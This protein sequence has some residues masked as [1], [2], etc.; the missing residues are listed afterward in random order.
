LYTATE[1]TTTNQR[2]NATIHTRDANHR[3]TQTDY[4]DGNGTLLARETFTYCDQADSQCSNNPLGHLKTHRLKNGAYVH[5]RYNPRGLLI[6]KW[7]PTWN[8]SASDAD[9]KTHYDY[10]TSGPWTDRVLTVTGPPPNW[11][12]SSQA[13]ET[14]EYDRAL[15]A[16]GITDLLNGAAQAGRGLVTKITHADGK[17]QRFAY[18]AYGNKRWEDN[19]LR[20]ATSY[21]YDEYNRLLNVTRPLNEITNY[22]YNPTNGGGSRLSHTTNNPDTVTVRT[23]ATTS[24]TTR[25]DYDENFRKTSATAADGTASAATTWFH[26]DNVGN[27]DYVTDPRGSSTPSAQWTTYTDYDSRNRK[28][29][30][31]EPLSRTTQFYYDDGFNLTR[32]V[33]AVGTPEVATETKVYDGLNRIKSD[34]VP[35]DT[36][37]NIVTQFQYNPWSGDPQTVDIRQPAPVIDG[38]SHNCQ[39]KYDAAGLKTQ[40]TYHDGSSQSWACD[41]AHNL[42]SRTTVAGEIQNFGYDNRNRKTLEWWDG[43]PADGEWRAF[44]YDDASHLTLATNGTGAYWANFIADVRRSYNAAGRLTMDRQTVYVNGVP[45]TKDVDYPTYT[46]DGRVTRM[47]VNGASPAYDYTFSYDRMGRFE[48]IQLTGSSVLFQ[49]HYDAASNDFQRDNLYNGVTQIYPRDE[50]NRMTNVELQGASSAAR[51]VYDYY[52]IGRLRTV[53]REDNKQDQFVY[54]LDSELKQVT[55]GVTATPPPTPTPPP[56]GTPAPPVAT[57]ATNVTGTGFSANWRSV[58][59]ATGYRLDVSTSSTFANYVTG[60]QNLNVGNVTSWAVSG[61]AGSTTYYYR[62]RAY[63]GNGTSG[64]S[65]VISVTT[66]TA[67]GQ[68]ATPT[69]NPDGADYVACY[70]TYTFN[71]TVSTTTSGAQIRWTIDGTPPTPTNGNLIN[72]SSG[73]A[74]FTVGSDQTKTLKA[75]AY[76]TGMA[77]SNIKSADF[78]FE[79]ECGGAPGYPLDNAGPP[80]AGPVAPDLSGTFTYTLNKAGNRTA[81]SGVSYS[82]NSINQY[83]SVGGSAVTNGTDHQI[84][85]YYVFHYTY[86]RD[87]ELTQITAPTVPGFSYDPAYNALG[88]CVKRSATANNTTTTTYYIYDGDKPI[89]EYNANN[90]L[91]G[92][93]VYG[94]EVDEILQRG[95]YGADNLWHW[96]F[97]NQDHEG[98][99]THLT[100]VYGTIIEKYRYDAF[101]TPSLYDG[102]GAQISTTAYN[103]RFLFTGREYLGAWVYDYRARVYNAYL[104]RFMSEDPK[105]FDAGDYNLF[106]YCHNDPLD[107][108]DPMGLWD[109]GDVKEA[110]YSLWYAGP[111]ATFD[112]QSVIGNTS[113]KFAVEQGRQATIDYKNDNAGE[114]VR[115]EVWQAELARKYGEKAAKAV[116]DAHEK[117][118]SRDAADSKRD[119]YHNELGRENSKTSQGREDSVRKAREDWESARAARDKF[120][121]RLNKSSDTK[122][123]TRTQKPP[124]ASSIEQRAIQQGAEKAAEKVSNAEHG[125]NPKPQ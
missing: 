45:I 68:V 117:Y 47:F 56:G 124:D 125:L 13:S 12:Y 30:V 118:K 14:Y 63:N 85:D 87:Q 41:D 116:G 72:A 37:V 70:N 24:I 115:H 75:M 94:K 23:S 33:R 122:S 29:Q 16:N 39:F 3:I 65:N 42:K 109:M 6:D 32:I 21:T 84:S 53:T 97:L 4:Q 98:S 79:H 54:Y 96:Y 58:N 1:Y 66:T 52:T 86:M 61:L 67:T 18:D 38:E 123:D 90:A 76:K 89:L 60:Y 71:V 50:L 51:E 20:N 121:P 31:R 88:R 44:G 110:A 77:N 74:S 2:R 8:S 119:Q 11:P 26:Y 107:L 22:T 81:V 7:E 25:N 10:Y 78:T 36:G 19:E 99:V 111:H 100:D 55:Y 34:T 57:A 113:G 28:W 62:V 83:T 59:G 120:D 105:L 102:G 64:N 95:A 114:A 15:G 91:V 93:N 73:V 27:Q 40:M 69:F 103:N 106:R 35:Q 48:K 108:T 5:Y 46:D 112:A 9:P 49:Y 43:W 17:F 82:P 101:G 104:G 80:P 92:F